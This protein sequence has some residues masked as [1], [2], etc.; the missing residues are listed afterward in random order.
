M[1]IG[2]PSHRPSQ[3]SGINGPDFEKTF[4]LPW[5]SSFKI[6]KI[7]LDGEIAPYCTLCFAH[8]SPRFLLWHRDTFFYLD[9]AFL[10]FLNFE[11]LMNYWSP[12]FYLGPK[13]GG[14]RRLGPCPR[15]EPN[16]MSSSLFNL[17]FVGAK[18]DREW[19]QEKEDLNSMRKSTYTTF[20]CV[21]SCSMHVHQCVSNGSERKFVR[22][23]GRKSIRTLSMYRFSMHQ[24]L[25][26][27]VSFQI[28]TIWFNSYWLLLFVIIVQT[29]VYN[30]KADPCG[31]VYI[32][33]GDGGNREG[34][35]MS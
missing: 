21:R 11:N 18:L 3:E 5:K 22:S 15:A 29:R 24:Q 17:S 31:P 32:T 28:L 14:S 9:I 1:C 10:N 27:L 25:R 20:D 12:L 16:S 26:G 23:C 8:R 34:L 4:S 33:I 6:S 19:E 30:N 2:T 13:I 35:A 7:L